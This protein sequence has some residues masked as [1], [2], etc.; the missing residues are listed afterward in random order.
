MGIKAKARLLKQPGRTVLALA[1]PPGYVISPQTI[2][3]VDLLGNLSAGVWAVGLHS[4]S[5]PVSDPGDLIAQ[6]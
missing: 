6:A 2:P 3:T 5:E 1:D 4:R